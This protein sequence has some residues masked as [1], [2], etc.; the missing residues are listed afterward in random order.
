[1]AQRLMPRRISIL[2]LCFTALALGAAA[3]GG[4]DDERRGAE[5]FAGEELVLL[6]HDSF[7]ITQDTITAFEDEFDVTVKIVPTGDAV[8]ALNRAILTKGNPEGDLLFGV[9]NISFVRALEENVFVEYRP[10]ALDSIDPS[11]IFDDSGH[12]TPVDFGYVLFNYEK[13]ALD[14]AGLAPPAALEDL[15]LPDWRGL[16]AVQDPNTSSPGLQFMLVTIAYFGENGA[17]TWLDFWRDLRANDVIV[18]TSWTDAYYTQFSQY[19]GTALLVNSYAT[20]PYAEFVF[21]EEPLDESPTANLIIPGASYLQ[22]EGVGILRGSDKQ[23]LARAFI[24]FMLS[25]RFQEDIP[26]NMFVYPARTD[27]GLPPDL[28]RFS[29]VPEEPAVVDAA[30]VGENL[31]R[32]LDEW[33]DTV[34]R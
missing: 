9:D 14:A 27:A 21:A 28:V 30:R 7:A 3:C 32:W 24:D 26:A 23:P 6:T 33:T 11:L 5:D 31:E 17:Y 15:A 12:L 18:S 10:P 2:F 1:M 4:D 19:D 20:S 16:V 29:E 13:A 8:E 34:L 22:I 25:R